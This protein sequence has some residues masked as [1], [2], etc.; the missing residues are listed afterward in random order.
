MVNLKI[1]NKKEETKSDLTKRVIGCVE[2]D[3]RQTYHRED[4]FKWPLF[5]SLCADHQSVV[6][7]TIFRLPNKYQT[8]WM[9][10]RSRHW[11]LTDYVLVRQRDMKIFISQVFSVMQTT[12][13]IT[14]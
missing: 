9:H 4:E 6:S 7:N 5:L 10:P 2:G 12:G 3:D 14:D 13:Q 1:K 11:Y 8:M